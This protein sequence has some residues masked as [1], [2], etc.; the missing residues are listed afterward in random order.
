MIRAIIILAAL[1]GL[2]ACSR[3]DPTDWSG[4]ARGIHKIYQTEGN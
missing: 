1:I 4:V 3:P 2:S